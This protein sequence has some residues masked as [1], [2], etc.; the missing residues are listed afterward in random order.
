MRSQLSC[1]ALAVCIFSADPALAQNDSPPK[2]NQEPQTVTEKLKG[3]ANS[4]LHDVRDEA[5]GSWRR[6]R[7]RN[8]GVTHEFFGMDAVVNDAGEA[9]AFLA[10]RL[11][12]SFESGASN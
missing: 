8:Y 10:Q 5:Q 2:S 9:Q 4:V 3:V 12:A 6:R 11:R 1:A 7:A